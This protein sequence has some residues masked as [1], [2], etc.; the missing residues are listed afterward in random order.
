MFIKLFGKKKRDTW[1]V[2]D[3]RSVE[4][5]PMYD[6]EEEGIYLLHFDFIPLKTNLD[7]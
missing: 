1:E 2:V 4:P 5:V 6:D 7:E 3:S